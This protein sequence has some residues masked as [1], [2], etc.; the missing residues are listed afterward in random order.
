MSYTLTVLLAWPWLA[1]VDMALRNSGASPAR[2]WDWKRLRILPLQLSSKKQRSIVPSSSQCSLSREGHKLKDMKG[3]DISPL[4]LKGSHAS[5]ELV[6]LDARHTLVADGNIHRQEGRREERE[7][8]RRMDLFFSSLALLS[9]ISYI[10]RLNNYLDLERGLE[11]PDS[12]TAAEDYSSKTIRS[13]MEMA[14][15]FI[16]INSQDMEHDSIRI[17][18][19]QGLIFFVPFALASRGP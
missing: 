3:M 18:R 4:K 11:N 19:F 17:P 9:E 14:G 6:A 13:R 8:K 2:F 12:K 7:G 5:W 10:S 15:V 1:R 16:F